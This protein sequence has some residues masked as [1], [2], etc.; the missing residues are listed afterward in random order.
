[1]SKSMLD[2]C[3]D[4]LDPLHVCWP[5]GGSPPEMIERVSPLVPLLT[6]SR[7]TLTNRGLR[8]TT[9]GQ[10]SP[11]L[12]HEQI[13]ASISHSFSTDDNFCRDMNDVAYISWLKSE[14]H[15][16]VVVSSLSIFSFFFEL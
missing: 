10:S 6:W 11:D 1:M 9:T 12:T 4:A 16:S 5:H 2:S 8:D 13:K 15:V 14:Y 7:R 3:S